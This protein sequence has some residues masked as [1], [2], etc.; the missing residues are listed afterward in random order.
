MLL[1]GNSD[2]CRQRISSANIVD[3]DGHHDIIHYINNKIR[4]WLLQ[5][6]TKLKCSQI[7]NKKL[8]QVH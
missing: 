1:L 7:N 6:L 5:Y 2:H 8:N 4:Q 3:Q